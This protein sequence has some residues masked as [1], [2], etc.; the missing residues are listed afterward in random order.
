[1]KKQT[2]PRFRITISDVNQKRLRILGYLFLSGILG[3]VLATY[4]VNNPA[5][6]TVLAPAIN[7]IIYSIVE[8]LKNNGYAQ[9]IRNEKR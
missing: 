8:E 5:L 6:T 3:Y 7:F 1:M 4:V 2:S 9:A